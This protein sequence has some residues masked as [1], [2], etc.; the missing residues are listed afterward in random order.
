MTIV[1]AFVS[2]FVRFHVCVRCCFVLDC[3]MLLKTTMKE[4]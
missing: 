3:S 2:Q 1:G 4:K